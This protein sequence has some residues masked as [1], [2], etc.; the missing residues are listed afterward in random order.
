MND[1]VP[2]RPKFAPSKPSNALCAM[3]MYADIAVVF[4][5]KALLRPMFLNARVMSGC[6]SF[7][8]SGQD[9]RGVMCRS[10]TIAVSLGYYCIPI[11]E[12]R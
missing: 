9:A 3:V 12:G 4:P 8:I 6:L 2:V 5:R 10:M 11:S 1:C 7:A